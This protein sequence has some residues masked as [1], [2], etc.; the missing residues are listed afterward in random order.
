VHR[1]TCEACR[2]LEAEVGND[3]EGKPRRG[4]KYAVIRTS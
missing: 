1:E 2:I 3:A 4:L